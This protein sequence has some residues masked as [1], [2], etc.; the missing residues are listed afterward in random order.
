MIYVKSVFLMSG[1]KE[2]I[3]IGVY[4]QKD[5]NYSL[6]VFYFAPFQ[7]LRDILYFYVEYVR[8]FF[9]KFGTKAP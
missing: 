5:P 2:R 4:F 8:L 9:I 3:R 1:I 6:K 7:K